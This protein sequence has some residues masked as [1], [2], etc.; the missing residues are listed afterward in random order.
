MDG[1]CHCRPGWTLLDC[2]K[3]VWDGG[4]VRSDFSESS[5]G[6]RVHNNSCPGL[7]EVGAV[8]LL[9]SADPWRLNAPGNPKP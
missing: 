3:K 7:L 2:S 4:V 6:W 1:S 9:S 8:Q 5:E